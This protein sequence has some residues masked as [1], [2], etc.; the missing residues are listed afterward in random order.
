MDIKVQKYAYGQRSSCNLG[1]IMLLSRVLPQ[2]EIG[3]VVLVRVGTVQ[4]EGKLLSKDIVQS[5]WVEIY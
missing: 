3:I 5:K 2:S 4:A 1:G